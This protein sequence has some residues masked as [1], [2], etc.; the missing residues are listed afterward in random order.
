[1]WL[2]FLMAA[3]WNHAVIGVPNGYQMS[4]PTYLTSSPPHQ[5]SSPVVIQANNTPVSA[6]LVVS[7]F[8]W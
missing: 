1:M 5:S 3:S 2:I 4:S 8:L 6:Q 7:V